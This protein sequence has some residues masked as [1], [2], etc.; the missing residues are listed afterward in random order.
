MIKN[1]QQLLAMLVVVL[2][3][4]NV[5]SSEQPTEDYELAF[6]LSD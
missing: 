3:R 4:Y 2:Y 6:H 5:S 1:H